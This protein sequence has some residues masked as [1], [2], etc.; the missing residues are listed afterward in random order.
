MTAY[1]MSPVMKHWIL[2]LIVGIQ[3]LIVIKE[4][5]TYSEAPMQAI[6]HNCY[7]LLIVQQSIPISIEYGKDG[8]NHVLTKTVSS[9]YL[10]G[11]CK[12]ICKHEFF[13]NI[14]IFSDWQSNTPLE[15]ARSANVYIRMAIVKSS[16]L[17][18]K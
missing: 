6:L 16:K 2:G 4:T 11:T 10:C 13:T 7:K 1:A 14:M 18:K 17:F 15:M 12:L 3:S 9:A 8:V 5:T